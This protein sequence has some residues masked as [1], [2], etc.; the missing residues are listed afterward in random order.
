ML[1]FLILLLLG[2]LIFLVAAWPI[3][4]IVNK[5]SAQQASSASRYFAL[6]LWPY[7]FY[8]SLIPLW[9]TLW[10]PSWIIH[11]LLPDPVATVIILLIWFIFLFTESSL[12]LCYAPGWIARNV[13]WSDTRIKLLATGCSVPYPALI[14]FVLYNYAVAT[15]WLELF[16]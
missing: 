9:L 14:I 5:R 7:V 3:S 10:I 1:I 6:S 11:L 15:K 8:G 16:L 12:F 4:S 13:S 2:P